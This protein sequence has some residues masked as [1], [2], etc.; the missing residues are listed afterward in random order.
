MYLI[1]LGRL[2]SRGVLGAGDAVYGGIIDNTASSRE[3]MSIT[4]ALC[5][6]IMHTFRDLRIAVLV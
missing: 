6:S 5:C 3:Y 1:Y 4:C 2:L